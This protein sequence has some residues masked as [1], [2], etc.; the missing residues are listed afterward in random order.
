MR[1]LSLYKRYE[2]ELLL[3]LV[4]I[5]WALCYFSINN[6]SE[7]RETHILA[8]G[9]EKNIPF[10]PAFIVFYVLAYIVVIIPYFIIRDKK[11]YRKAVL[12]YLFVIF[13]SSI[14]YLIYPVKTIRPDIE[15]NGFFLSIV[16]LVYSVAKPYNLFPSLHVSLST[17]SA[18]V[19][20]KYNKRIGYVLFVLLFFISI[21]TLFVKQHYFIDIIAALALGFF[22]YYLFFVRKIV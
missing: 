3:F 6:F 4:V 13:F 17:L 21:S 9:F 15:G 11:D 7:G 19:S 8:L 1:F 12:A 22:S 16:A 20:F 18:L 2:K 10:I 5:V 14:I